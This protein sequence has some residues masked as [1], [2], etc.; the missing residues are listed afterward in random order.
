[1]CRLG[2]LLAEPRYLDAA[3]RT[4]RAAWTS[5]EEYPRAH[6]S[7]MDAL[8][9]FLG[10]LQVLIIRD[11]AAAGAPADSSWAGAL[12]ALYAPDRMIF[13]IPADAAGLPRSLAEKR[14]LDG[15]TAYVCTGMTCSAPF[16]DLAVL[17][18]HLATT[19]PQSAA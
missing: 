8:E 9:D 5:M 4:L 16:T 13:S 10:P 2:Y 12:G 11:D 18:R 1:L 14:V 17:A 19:A 7:F 3:E 15:T 6:M